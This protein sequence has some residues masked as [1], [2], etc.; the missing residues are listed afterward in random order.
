VKHQPQRIF[1][2]SI[3]MIF[4]QTSLHASCINIAVSESSW[5][6][7]RVP[8]NNS[9]AVDKFRI[10][11][12]RF[13]GMGSSTNNSDQQNLTFFFVPQA[14][15]DALSSTFYAEFRYVYRMFLSG[16]V[17]LIQRNLNVQN[18]T[19]RAHETGRNFL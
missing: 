3:F 4:R 13:S 7:C 14:S 17:S 15:I 11:T 10:V 1:N 6:M 5:T 18:S 19:L 16:R 8:L 12:L 2:A 9:N